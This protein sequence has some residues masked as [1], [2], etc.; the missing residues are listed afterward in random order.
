MSFIPDTTG[1][2]ESVKQGVATGQIKSKQGFFKGLGGIIGQIFGSGINYR[3]D[4]DLINELGE[5]SEAA[6]R[7]AQV[8]NIIIILL[9]VLV[10]GGLLYFILKKK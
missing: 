6:R 2:Q 10:F 3:S 9:V 7:Q 4:D 8:Q 1:I 5:Q